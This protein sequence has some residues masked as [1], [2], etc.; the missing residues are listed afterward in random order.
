MH[1]PLLYTHIHCMQLFIQLSTNQS[2]YLSIYLSLFLPIFLPP[3]RPP[4]LAGMQRCV[5]SLENH[6]NLLIWMKAYICPMTRRYC[7]TKNKAPSWA[8]AHLSRVF[9]HRISFLNSSRYWP[10]MD[11]RVGWTRIFYANINRVP[12]A[13]NSFREENTIPQLISL[14]IQQVLCAITWK[15]SFF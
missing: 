12:G 4:L 14:L 7:A 10:R 3:T 6:W 5:E 2:F 11:S 15:K 8:G 9:I 1:L 13:V